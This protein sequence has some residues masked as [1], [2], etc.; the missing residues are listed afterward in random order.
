MNRFFKDKTVVVTG[1]SRGI[2][3]ELVLQSLS[4]GASVSALSRDKSA[5]QEIANESSALPG[6]LLTIGCDI[7]DVDSVKAAFQKCTAQYGHIDILVNNAG[8]GLCGPALKTGPEDVDSCFR[9]N[10]TGAVNCINEAAPGMLERKA[11]TIVNVASIV[12]K[13]GLPTVSFYSA[14]KAALAEYSRALGME[15]GPGGVRVITV[16]PGNTATSFHDSQVRAGGYEP[17]RVSGRPMSPKYVAGKILAGISKGGKDEIVIGFAGRVMLLMGRLVP[18]YLKRLLTREFDLDSWYRTVP[19]RYYAAVD[20]GVSLKSMLKTCSYHKSCAEI[21]GSR[22]LPGGLSPV[23]HYLLY[24]YLL[25]TAYGGRVDREQKF[26]HPAAED[27]KFSIIRKKPGIV[28]WCKNVIKTMLAPVMPMGRVKAQPWIRIGEKEYPFNLG[29]GGTACPAAFRSFFP[30]MAERTGGSGKT[31]DVCCPDHLKNLVFGS[32]GE[33]D[34]PELICRWGEDARFS[35]V[36]PCARINAG[37]DGS[38]DDIA[39]RIGCPCATL[40]N[41]ALGYY[42]TLA[43]GGELAFYSK[44]FDAA[45]F[46]CPNPRARVVLEIKRKENTIEFVVKDVIGGSCPKDIKKGNLFNLPREI[47]RNTFCLHAFNVLYFYGGVAGQYDGPL[48]VRC[49]LDDCN[50]EWIVNS[51][52]AEGS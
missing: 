52:Q 4:A 27:V 20:A 16:F 10:F 3:R 49:I 42:F 7:T 47:D 43:R 12:A 40:L 41:I 31:V 35:T 6:R 44:S 5:L 11:G 30:I 23:I 19:D 2:G 24:P 32:G 29:S 46:Q 51:G 33:M 37:A 25:S 34:E 26:R 36:T 50:A 48:K 15:L 14:A 45:V 18:G 21:K 13:Y 17:G 22:L 38:L 9:T 1:A 28:E 8:A 39:G